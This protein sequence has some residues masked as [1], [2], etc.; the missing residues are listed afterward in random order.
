MSES[1]RNSTL[2]VRIVHFQPPPAATSRLPSGFFRRTLKPMK[3]LLTL[4]LVFMALQPPVLQACAMDDHESAAHHASM[5]DHG[6]SDC[7]QSD[8]ADP[9]DGCDEA[10]QCAFFSFGFVVIPAASAMT[11]MPAQHRY[12][13]IDNNPYSGPPARRLFRPPIA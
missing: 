5:V 11:V 1:V 3:Y 2:F 6:E 7:C 9:A 12:D 13:P 4:F 10:A 8:N